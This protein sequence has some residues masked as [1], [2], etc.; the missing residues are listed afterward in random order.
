VKRLSLSVSFWTPFVFAALL[1]LMALM[2]PE[3]AEL[4][5]FSFLPL[6]FM[7]VAI[8]FGRLYSELRRLEQKVDSDRSTIQ[9]HVAPASM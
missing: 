1:C 5:F 3:A 7:F 9:F 8:A 4:P 2:L 6:A